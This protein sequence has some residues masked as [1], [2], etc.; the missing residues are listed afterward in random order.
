MQRSRVLSSR[1]AIAFQATVLLAA[2]GFVAPADAAELIQ[3]NGK[4]FTLPDGFTIEVAAAPPMVDRPIEC[5][6]D[7]QGR[8]YVSDSSGS[9]DDPHKQVKAHRI[10]RL[11][12][13]R[14]DGVFDQRTVF[15]DKMTFPEGVLW[16]G[17]SLYVAGVPSIWKFN[18]SG[19][20]VEWF[21]GKTITG[22]ANDLHGPYA[23][24]DGWIY[25]CKGAF[26]SQTYEHAGLP[27]RT[28]GGQRKALVSRAAH[29]FRARPDGTGIEPVMSGGM[30]NPVE[31]TFT[32]GG[33]RIFTTTFLQNP[34]GGRRDG[35]IHAVYGGVYGKVSDVIDDLPR[36]GPDLMP[37]LSHL[38]PAACCG[39]TRYES[40]VFG[41]QYRDNLFVTCFNLHKVTRHELTPAGATFSSRDSDFL[42]CDNVDFHPT[43]V[44]EDADGSLLVI[45][46]GGWYH[47]CCPTSQFGK[48]DVLGAIYRVRKNDAF[49]LH[50]PRGLK[51]AWDKMSPDD[52]AALLDGP[53][54]IRKRAV[55]ALASKAEA[56]LPA[57]RRVMNDQSKSSAAVRL[58]AV[59]AATR[60]DLPAARAIVADALKDSDETV[61]QAAAHSASLWRDRSAEPMLLELLRTGT[62][63]N[64]R[65][66]AEALGRLGDAASVPGLLAAIAGADP[67][68]RVLG[69]SLTYAMMEIDEPSATAAG[70]GD[71]N[72]R[73][74]Q[75]ALVALDQ[76]DGGGLTAQAVAEAL[77][78]PDPS[79]HET[80][81]WVAGRHAEW[82][83]SFVSA[84]D[85]QWS[86]AN[87]TPE[88]QSRLVKEAADLAR[89]PI[90]QDWLAAKA[91]GGGSGS[92]RRLALQ[93]MAQAGLKET[94][95]SWR[96]AVAIALADRDA[97]M[98]ADAVA[99]AGTFSK[100][101]GAAPDIDSALSEIG[102]RAELPPS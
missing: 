101:K 93:A 48:P 33:E 43:D 81:A 37:V 88:D 86:A 8:L 72:P 14:G 70:L 46:T 102:A 30:D 11:D 22:C 3:L 39:L 76:M 35:L 17:D 36:T 85:Q 47:L 42:V 91:A 19:D 89:S 77:A 5:D 15:A 84:L 26:A 25:W 31:V 41:P 23:G 99:A 50:D 67:G 45:D 73:V 55:A 59:W 78:S 63:Q 58:N 28:S 74:R 13:S 100:G 62:P 80:A 60:I 27:S 69:H 79:L 7:D 51:L 64:Q 75:S 1:G 9:N 94:P 38:G 24:P 71:A 83:G 20:R 18:G 40:E 32:A 34:A 56:A 57:I 29:I 54:A 16:L 4:N 61:R 98:L 90:V 68:D 65:V 92:T 53:P 87:L 44:V 95:G 96:K 82:A 2:I 12:S 6:F 97:D 66:A 49:P 52:L 10:L 21:A